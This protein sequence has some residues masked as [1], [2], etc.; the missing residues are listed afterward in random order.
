[1]SCI[2]WLGGSSHGN[3][4]SEVVELRSR[5]LKVKT[6]AKVV[7]IRLKPLKFEIKIPKMRRSKSRKR[8]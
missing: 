4:R 1:M 7:K 8:R 5:K 6:R 2:G 3:K